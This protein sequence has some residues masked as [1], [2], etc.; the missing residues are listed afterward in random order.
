[1]FACDYKRFMELVN[2]VTYI[3]VTKVIGLL[4]K[5]EYSHMVN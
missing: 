2:K 3:L 4:W 5:L 1:M